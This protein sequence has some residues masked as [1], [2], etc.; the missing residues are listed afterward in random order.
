KDP[1]ATVH[2]SRVQARSQNWFE[3]TNGTDRT[4]TTRGLYLSD[5]Y[6]SDDDDG[7]VRRPHDHKYRM[8]ALIIRPGQTVFF[9]LSS[10]DTDEPLKRA[11]TNFSLSYGERFRLADARGNIIQHVDISL[12]NHSQVQTRGGDGFWTIV[13]GPCRDCGRC[14]CR[15][16]FGATEGRCGARTCARCWCTTCDRLE[17]AC[18]CGPR[19]GAPLLTGDVDGVHLNVTGNRLEVTAQSMGS[20]FTI[21]LRL[22]N[23]AV[24]SGGPWAPPEVSWAISGD[25]LTIT[26]TGRPGWGNGL[27][28]CEVRWE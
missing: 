6:G 20:S 11:R 22:P 4:L 10:N 17:T 19:P 5:N 2:I 1:T 21:Q 27:G 12:M 23:S 8:P 9:A 3:I 18:V 7:T 13:D 14:G 28:S 16:C 26:A 15:Q 25:I 24:L